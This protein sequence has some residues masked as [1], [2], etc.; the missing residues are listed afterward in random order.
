[1]A[2]TTQSPAR[3]LVNVPKTAKRGDVIEIKTLISHIME[4]GFRHDT[5][6]KLVPRN[7]IT[8]FECRY[9]GA[10]IFAADLSPAIAAN[11]FLT[12]FTV[13]TASGPIDFSWTG[14]NGFAATH[15]AMLTV[16]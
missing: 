4:T 13:A 6:G 16:A 11:P 1:M 14:D 9:D 8:R 3:A 7:I 2:E 10:V 12:F 5:S 15:Q